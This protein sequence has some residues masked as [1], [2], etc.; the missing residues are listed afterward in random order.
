M[1]SCLQAIRQGE[2]SRAG[3]VSD[4]ETRK[5]SSNPWQK[6]DGVYFDGT[7]YRSEPLSFELCHKSEAEGWQPFWDVASTPYEK[8]F[9][10]DDPWSLEY[11]E[12][13]GLTPD[14]NAYELIGYAWKGL[15][16]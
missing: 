14:G 13:M 6:R 2:W 16:E 4:S 9:G 10:M 7:Y 15:T 8:R 3:A 5:Q 12:S 11:R 1:T